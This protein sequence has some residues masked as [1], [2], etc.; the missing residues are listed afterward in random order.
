VKQDPKKAFP[1]QGPVAIIGIGC[2][3]PKAANLNEFWSNIRGSVDAITEMPDTHWHPD[4]YHDEDPGAPDKTYGRR[5]GF[6]ETIDFNP[7]EFGIS[8]RD[9]EATDT[10]QLLG[11]AVAKRALQDAG[12]P[13]DGDRFDRDR[14]SVLLGVTGTLELVIPLGARLGHPIWRRALADA[15]IDSQTAEDAIERIKDGYVSWQENSFPGLLGNVVAGR[16]ANRLD[17]HG[18]NCVVDAACA[19]SLSAVHLGVLELEAGRADMVVTGGV[20]TF[21]DIFMYMCF[22]KTPAL[23]PTGDARPFA[24][25]GDGTI[26]GEGLGMLVLKRLADAER[27]GDRIYAVIRG[28]GTASDGKG[29]AVYAPTA[30]GQARA[31]RNAY[32]NAGIEPETIE[33]IEAHGTGTKVGDATEIEGLKKVFGDGGRAEPWC[34]LGSV[35]SMIGHTKA[36]AGAAGLIKA[37][38][39]LHHRVLPPTIKVDKP[40]AAATGK[41]PFYINTEQR[42]WLPQ[43]DHP[44][45][46]AVSAFGF[47]G[48]NFHCV[49]E[50][51]S[52]NEPAIDWDGRVQ[53]LAL[54]AGDRAALAADLAATIERIEADASWDTLRGEA[55][56]SR[57]SFDGGAQCRLVCV[58]ERDR[59]QP[60]E[61][62]RAAAELL[63]RNADHDHWESPKGIYF[64]EGVA[65]G[66]LGAVFPG[67]GSQH[68]GMMRDL[69]CRFPAVRNA[70]ADAGAATPD[71]NDTVYPHP[72]FDDAARE[73]QSDRLRRTEVA[74][75]AIGAGAARF[76]RGVL[77]GG[78]SQLR[79]DHGAVCFGP[80]R[81][82]GFSSTLTSARRTDGGGRRRPR[83]D[84][85]RHGRP[86]D[87]RCFRLASRPVAGRRESQRAAPDGA[88]GN[89]RGDR[90]G[91]GVAAERG[92]SL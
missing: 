51:Y 7:M 55:A 87:R 13:A 39:A 69:S 48:S 81:Q 79:R 16:I 83:H 10:S 1:K 60:V 44:R 46:A 24:D 70:L 84:A 40:N 64:A 3:F 57:A 20:D 52:K 9:V 56:R 30:A 33:L 5:G 22:S 63:E 90:A 91:R 34:A 74:Q 26:L 88:V 21:N 78:R 72:A 27:D 19:S 18:T 23:S 45:R 4:D 54:A 65:Q 37:A 53:V 80:Y 75:P 66:G 38:M 32:R 61:M 28:M 50:E 68:P 89:D 25:A 43:P 17:L 41:T 8:P 6:L 59:S 85:G 49:L 67:Q 36:A 82:S 58:I 86:C 92:R 73:A 77:G 35:K 47:G 29:D 11:L 62:L 31:L 76:R 42:P 14:C 12:Y 15:G 71:L 2:M